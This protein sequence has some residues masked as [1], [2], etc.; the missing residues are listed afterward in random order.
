MEKKG[1]SRKV[2]LYTTPTCTYCRLVKDLL[3]EEKAEYE[4][5]D[6]TKDPRYVEDL[7]RKSGQLGVPV[8]D[9]GGKIIV[10]FQKEP[11][12]RALKA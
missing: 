11:I 7:L 9:V 3:K 2:L 10:G 5:I 8:L 4:E 1:S 6:V 12:K